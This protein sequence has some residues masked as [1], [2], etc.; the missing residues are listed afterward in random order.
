MEDY[1]KNESYYPYEGG[2][3][4]IELRDSELERLAKALNFFNEDFKEETKK[5]L[6]L[7]KNYKLY[8]D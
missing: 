2:V 7:S 5:N 8:R 6:I 4:R 1:N 3:D